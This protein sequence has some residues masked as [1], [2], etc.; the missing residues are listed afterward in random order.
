MFNNGRIPSPIHQQNPELTQQC[1]LRIRQM[2][3]SFQMQNYLK[4]D[5]KLTASKTMAQKI[6]EK[7]KIGSKKFTGNDCFTKRDRSYGIQ[8]LFYLHREKDYKI[9]TLFTAAGIFDRY[10]NILGYQ[11][12][13]RE[14]VITLSTISTLM[15]AKLEQPISPSFSRMISLLSSDEQQI[16]TK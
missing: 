16:V 6:Q 8:K 9:E 13:P 15:A 10:I 12:F 1:Y 11:N 14:Q 4:K 5:K 3:E 7:F 2:E